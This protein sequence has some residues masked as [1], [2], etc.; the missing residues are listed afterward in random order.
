MSECVETGYSRNKGG[1]GRVAV[2]RFGRRVY[3]AHVM[4]WVDAHGQLPP[5]DAPCILHSCDNPPCVNVEHL[6]AGTHADNMQQMKEKGRVVNVK[7]FW[8]HCPEGHE[9]TAEN[10]KICGNGRRRCRKCLNAAKRR[11]YHES[12]AS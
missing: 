6:S 5:D 12:K 2:T 1:Y 10:T 7:A 3:L 8:T 11:L 9:F 4:A